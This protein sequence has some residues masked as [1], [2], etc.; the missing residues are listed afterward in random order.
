MLFTL[1]VVTVIFAVLAS[2]NAL[3]SHSENKMIMGIAKYHK[4][5]GLLA[6]LFGIAHMVFAIM[7]NQLRITGLLVILSLVLTGLFG[8]LFYKT[9]TIW[10]YKVHRLLGPLT[11]L[12]I[13]I[14]VLLNTNF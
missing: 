14:H 3:K 5:F 8:M 4:I 6:I 10:M 9:K 2:V 13:L 7:D 11:I 1:G 12:L